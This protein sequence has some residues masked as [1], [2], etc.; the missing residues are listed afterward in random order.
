MSYCARLTRS[1][2][3]VIVVLWL[4]ASRSFVVHVCRDPHPSILFSVLLSD[5]CPIVVLVINGLRHRSPRTREK[6]SRFICSGPTQEPRWTVLG[7][8]TALPLQVGPDI[9]I[10]TTTRCTLAH[11]ALP[12]EQAFR[13]ILPCNHPPGWYVPGLAVTA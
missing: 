6:F 2:S 10:G 7:P 4:C 11:L 8:L 9:A 1:Y 13:S 12:L 5:P 3:E